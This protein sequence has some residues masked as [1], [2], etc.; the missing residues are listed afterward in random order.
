M[1]LLE[2]INIRKL[3]GKTFDKWKCHRH[4]SKTIDLVA[5]KNFQQH[6]FFFC[7]RSEHILKLSPWQN[8]FHFVKL[9]QFLLGLLSALLFGSFFKFLLSHGCDHLIHEFIWS[10]YLIYV[11]IST[12]ICSKS[13]IFLDESKLKQHIKVNYPV[14]R[15]HGK[16]VESD[17]PT[18]RKS[19][20]F[21]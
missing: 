18:Q 21:D 15:I 13:K 3:C 12:E 1:N 20:L 19:L 8:S 10:D 6:L 2:I 5:S 9:F 11:P 17:L 14:T 7:K 4:L 16:A